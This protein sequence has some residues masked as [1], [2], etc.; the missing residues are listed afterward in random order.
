MKGYYCIA[1]LILAI[2]IFQGCTPKP[3]CTLTLE[4]SPEI[5]GFKLGQKHSD[6]RN[7]FKSGTG[8]KSYVFGGKITISGEPFKGLPE[9]EEE[10]KDDPRLF[11]LG[12]ALD[13]ALELPDE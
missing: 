4:N 2:L 13:K 11:E 7:R 10:L 3:Q 6:V 1:S 8:R 12:Q 5:R 9:F